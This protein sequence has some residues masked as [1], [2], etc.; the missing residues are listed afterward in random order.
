[1]VLA[2]PLQSAKLNYQCD[3]RLFKTSLTIKIVILIVSNIFPNN[4][5]YYPSVYLY[6]KRRKSDLC[7]AT[8]SLLKLAN[9]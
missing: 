7:A 3:S 6:S 4:E 9:V 1:M 2:F 5:F 8:Y